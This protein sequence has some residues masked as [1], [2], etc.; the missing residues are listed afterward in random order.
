MTPR[1][2]QSLRWFIGLSLLGGGVALLAGAAQFG[3]LGGASPWVIPLAGLVAAVLAV[4]TATVERG[5]WSPIVPAT[6]W[7]VSVLAA[8][9]W[10]HLDRTNGHPFLSGYA[11]IVA[12][13][14][15]LG[16][17]WRQLWAWPVGF[18]SVVGF[19]PIV[20]ILA[21][22]GAESVAAGFVLFAADVVALLAIQRS[23]FGPR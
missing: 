2:E 3:R 6:A 12:F 9:L 16:I 19:G 21:P 11:A 22:L 7:I 15:G 5:P 13:A 1:V 18:A 23:Y 4:I 20:L 17:L 10:A 14:T 8:I